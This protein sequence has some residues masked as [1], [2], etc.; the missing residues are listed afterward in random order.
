MI[1]D[2]ACG[3]ITTNYLATANGNGFTDALKSSFEDIKKVLDYKS[4]ISKVLPYS[5]TGTSAS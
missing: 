2:D 1:L 4:W 3:A 5:K